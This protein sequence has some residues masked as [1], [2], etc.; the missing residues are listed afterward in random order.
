MITDDQ[1]IIILNRF[2][3]ITSHH[4]LFRFEMVKAF[5]GFVINPNARELLGGST[6]LHEYWVGTR[7]DIYFDMGTFVRLGSETEGA[8]RDYYMF[9]LKLP[10]L[11]ELKSSLPKAGPV[12]QRVKSG[13]TLQKLYLKDLK[14]N[15]EE[16]PEFALIKEFVIHRHLYAHNSGY[17]DEQFFKDMKEY[18]EID[19]LAN[20]PEFSELGWPTKDLVYTS[21]LRRIG[22]FSTAISSLF[23]KL[24]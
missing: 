2:K 13:D 6:T 24:P 3:R 17:L 22:E 10:N 16:F 14:I 7:S 20:D 9:S 23:K 11:N 4:N 12:F 18:C 8:F 1:R 15:L 5:K 21:P 19:L